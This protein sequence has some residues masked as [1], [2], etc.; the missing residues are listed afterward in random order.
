MIDLLLAF[1]LFIFVFIYICVAVFLCCYRFSVNKDLFIYYTR[2]VSM[3]GYI[4]ATPV[5]RRL[6]HTNRHRTARS[7]K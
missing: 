1:V 6:G 5:V 2:A 4:A 7:A 3:T